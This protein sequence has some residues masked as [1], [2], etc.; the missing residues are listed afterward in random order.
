MTCTGIMSCMRSCFDDLYRYDDLRNY[1]NER[2]IY[3]AK[4][5]DTIEEPWQKWELN[6]VDPAINSQLTPSQ[7][8][9]PNSNL[10]G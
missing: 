6:H 10:N 9:G 4:L 1:S 5:R 7:V 8:P 3:L 2:S